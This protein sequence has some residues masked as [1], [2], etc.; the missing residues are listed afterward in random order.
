[1]FKVI[2]QSPRYNALIFEAISALKEP[3]GSDVSAILSYIEVQYNFHSHLFL[4][5]HLVLPDGGH[6]L[7]VLQLNISISLLMLEKNLQA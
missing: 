1:M 6:Y 7:F 3:N 5:Q 4:Y 2:N